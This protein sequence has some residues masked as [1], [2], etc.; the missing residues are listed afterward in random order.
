MITSVSY[1]STETSVG[2][3][4]PKTKIKGISQCYECKSDNIEYDLDHDEIICK[5][6][7]LVLRQGITD[8]TPLTCA[9]FPVMSRENK[10]R[11]IKYD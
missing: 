1:I 8:Y 11:K 6:C 5:E 7:G 2:W 10:L 3:N 9:V 4:H